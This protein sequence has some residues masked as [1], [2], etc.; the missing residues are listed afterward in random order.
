MCTFFFFSF[1]KLA[2]KSVLDFSIMQSFNPEDLGTGVWHT[3]RVAKAG[4]T[5]NLLSLVP[6]WLKPLA[7]WNPPVPAPAAPPPLIPNES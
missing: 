3:E 6:V 1:K 2:V 4:L 7:L 5:V